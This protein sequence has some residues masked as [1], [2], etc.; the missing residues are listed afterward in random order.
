MRAPSL[1]THDMT[2]V[3]LDIEGKEFE[4]ELFGAVIGLGIGHA[5][6]LASA[7]GASSTFWALWRISSTEN[8]GHDA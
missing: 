2:C 5:I 3:I 7:F 6:D 4:M 8:C 1:L